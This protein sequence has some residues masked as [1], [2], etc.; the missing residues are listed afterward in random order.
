MARAKR[1]SHNLGVM[2]VAVNRL[3][4]LN[5]T[6]GPLAKDTLVQ[7]TESRLG[8]KDLPE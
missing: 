3:K 1:F 8:N 2:T 6:L 7:E 4:D 5:N